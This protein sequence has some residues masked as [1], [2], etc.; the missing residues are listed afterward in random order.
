MDYV[1]NKRYFKFPGPDGVLA[2]VGIIIGL[3]VIVVGAIIIFSANINQS[4]VDNFGE[5]YSD[6]MDMDLAEN[7]AVAESIGT[8]KTTLFVGLALLVISLVPYIIKYKRIPKD[9]ELDMQVQDVVNQLSKTA[10]IKHG[11]TEEQVQRSA[12]IV[13]GGYMLAEGITAKLFAKKHVKNQVVGGKTTS[14]VVDPAVVMGSVM[15]SSVITGGNIPVVKYKKGF[16]DV[17]VRST[18]AEYTIFLF[19]E[20]KVFVYTQ[21]FSL[22]DPETKESVHTYAYRDI[23]S[24]SSEALKYG[25]HAFIVKASNGEILTVPCSNAKATDIKN[26]VTAFMQLVRDKKNS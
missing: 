7:K 23:V 8:G 13:F 11:I 12:P 2:I 4:F 26:S 5:F 17:K 18:L 6:A 1:R 22:V 20:D 21:Q 9:A 10:L 3:I 15:S 24:I 14:T 19:S 25:S 16:K